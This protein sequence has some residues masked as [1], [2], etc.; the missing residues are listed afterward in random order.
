MV[1]VVSDEGFSAL[2]KEVGGVG[3]PLV[4]V[5]VIAGVRC[6]LD[7]L[8][9]GE[10]SVACLHPFAVVPQVIGVVVVGL[11]LTQVAEELIES[12]QVGFAALPWAPQAPF[13]KGAR[14]IALLLQQT[15]EGGSFGRQ[16]YLAFAMR[17]VLAMRAAV[18]PHVGV[19]GVQAR[20]QDAARWGTDRVPSIVAGEA[21]ALV[22]QAIQVGRPDGLRTE[23]AEFGIAQVIR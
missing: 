18:V 14:G 3:L 19:T 20:Q 13:A 10:H 5:P 16:G 4:R 11:S 6:P 8:V 1:C 22:S 15:S 23:A 9:G 2:D 7:L 12:L 21:H 17:V